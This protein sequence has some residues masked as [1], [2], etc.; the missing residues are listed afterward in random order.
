MLRCEITRRNTQS[1]GPTSEPDRSDAQV[2]QVDLCSPT[3]HSGPVATLWARVTPRQA[4]RLRY[5]LG[6]VGMDL[7]ALLP[8]SWALGGG[9]SVHVAQEIFAGTPGSNVRSTWQ[10][11]DGR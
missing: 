8:W 5:G 4:A 10:V 9:M 3:F 6:E 7:T 2:S 1:A 11:H